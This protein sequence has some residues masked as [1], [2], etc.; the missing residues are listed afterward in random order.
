MSHIAPLIT[1]LIQTSS[2]LPAGRFW[3]LT[4]MVFTYMLGRLF[5]LWRMT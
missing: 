2:S 3:V 1:V 4:M 5:I